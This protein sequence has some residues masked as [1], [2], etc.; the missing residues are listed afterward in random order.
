MHKV[1]ISSTLA[2]RLLE[3]FADSLTEICD[4]RELRNQRATCILANN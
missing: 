1:A 4:R 3:L 2:L